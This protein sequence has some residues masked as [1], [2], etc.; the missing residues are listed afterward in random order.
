VELST[1]TQI[2]QRLE[3]A[4]ALAEALAKVK[5]RREL[6]AKADEIALLTGT[7]AR[8]L[9]LLKIAEQNKNFSISPANH[10]HCTQPRE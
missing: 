4:E 10:G 9:N 8:R 7:A 6:K 1:L 3:K 2:I 5:N